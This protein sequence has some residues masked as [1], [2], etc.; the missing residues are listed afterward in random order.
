LADIEKLAKSVREKMSA[1]VG[2]NNPPMNTGP[3]YFPPMG[4]RY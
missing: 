4:R 3:A 2:N 1:A